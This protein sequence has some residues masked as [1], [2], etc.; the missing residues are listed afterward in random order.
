[1]AAYGATLSLRHNGVNGVPDS[2][3]YKRLSRGTNA[4]RV[5]GS[6][7]ACGRCHFN[8]SR[9]ESLLQPSAKGHVEVLDLHDCLV[10]FKSLPAVLEP[11]ARSQAHLCQ[12][13]LEPGQGRRFRPYAASV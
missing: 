9:V 2:L 1:M 10:M 3:A 4:L 11:Q 5:S 12:S 8:F 6:F 7:R 13:R